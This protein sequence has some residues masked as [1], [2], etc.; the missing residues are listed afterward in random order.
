MV[1]NLAL[2]LRLTSYFVQE[3]VSHIWVTS[4]PQSLPPV[5]FRFKTLLSSTD[6]LPEIAH[7]LPRS[8][9]TE[10]KH[11]EQNKKQAKMF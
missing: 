1:S 7:P 4:D 3:T 5:S 9:A 8:D 11:C 2:V 10:I 6:S